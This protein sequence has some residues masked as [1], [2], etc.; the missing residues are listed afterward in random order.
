M[1]MNLMNVSVGYFYKHKNKIMS[2]SKELL[3]TNKLYS[4][5][6]GCNARI[7]KQGNVDFHEV[8]PQNALNSFFLTNM[9]KPPLQR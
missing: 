3:F 1:H 6:F 7:I 5:L 4:L 8:F 9:L 2:S